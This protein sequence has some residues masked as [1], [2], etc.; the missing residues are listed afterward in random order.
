MSCGEE[1]N[2]GHE[3]DTRQMDG[4][5]IDQASPVQ[6]ELVRHRLGDGPEKVTNLGK[7]DCVRSDY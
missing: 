5:R 6:V 7:V 2:F 4:S 1:V 3:F